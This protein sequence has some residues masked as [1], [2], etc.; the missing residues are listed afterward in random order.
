MR[1][2]KV[3]YWDYNHEHLNYEFYSSYKEAK[4]AG[5][6]NNYM[7]SKISKYDFPL[8]RKGF[9]EALNVLACHADNG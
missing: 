4:K 1:V 3:S 5:L 6:N 8:T 7:K 9:L 2:Y